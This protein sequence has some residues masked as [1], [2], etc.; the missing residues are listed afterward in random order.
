MVRIALPSNSQRQFHA[1]ERNISVSW[2]HAGHTDVYYQAK[3]SPRVSRDIRTQSSPQVEK[4][5]WI[6]P[7]QLRVPH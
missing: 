4:A 7:H 5:E 2:A 3:V 6:P 1:H